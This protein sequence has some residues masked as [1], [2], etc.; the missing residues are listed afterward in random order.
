MI[1]ILTYCWISQHVLDL[2]IDQEP[3]FL[4][5]SIHPLDIVQVKIPKGLGTFFTNWKSYKGLKLDVDA[6][7][8]DGNIVTYQSFDEY[9]G[10]LAVVFQTRYYLLKFFNDGDVVINIPLMFSHNFTI[11]ENK[12]FDY[13]NITQLEQAKGF[14]YQKDFNYLTSPFIVIS[15]EI[16]SFHNYLLAIVLV[17]FYIFSS[18]CIK[19]SCCSKEK[20]ETDVL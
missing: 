5:L 16:T 20:E 9:H 4:L 15:S 1:F 11:K 6:E 12:F 8:S 2:T 3:T 10:L 14:Y 19:Y 7:N 13:Y 18:I 17:F